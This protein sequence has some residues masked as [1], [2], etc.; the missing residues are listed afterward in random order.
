MWIDKVATSLNTT[1]TAVNNSAV[2]QCVGFN[3]SFFKNTAARAGAVLCSS[4]LM[5][6][7]V[8]SGAAQSCR[9]V[10]DCCV[11]TMSVVYYVV[12]RLYAALYNHI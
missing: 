11:S 6:V 1:A 12:Q 10:C 8:S 2:H 5:L 3:V 9:V 7:Q 4:T